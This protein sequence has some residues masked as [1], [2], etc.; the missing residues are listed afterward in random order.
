MGSEKQNWLKDVFLG[1][2]Q[3]DFVSIYKNLLNVLP[4]PAIVLDINSK[5]IIHYNANFL[6]LTSYS[7]DELVNLP[8]NS[9]FDI[10]L[11]LN[12][13]FVE[14]FPLELTKRNKQTIEG[15]AWK[16]NFDDK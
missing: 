10:E 8:V 12:S 4:D 1:K 13:D 16:Y 5:E 2:S 14:P 6:K 7:P 3:D 9:L 15:Y 11:I